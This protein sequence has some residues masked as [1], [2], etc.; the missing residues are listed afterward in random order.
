[1]QV[2]E[3][4]AKRYGKKSLDRSLGLQKVEAHR[5]SRQLAH[6]GGKVQSSGVR[7]MNAQKF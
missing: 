6:E 5:I 2:S 7:N 3:V 1:M 4:K